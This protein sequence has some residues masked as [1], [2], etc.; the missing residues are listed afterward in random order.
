MIL[1]TVQPEWIEVTAEVDIDDT[2][3]PLP[4]TSFG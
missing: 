2:S 4:L 3:G 1:L